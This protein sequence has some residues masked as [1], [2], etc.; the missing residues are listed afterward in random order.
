MKDGRIVEAGEAEAL[1]RNPR[2]PYTR[3]LMAAAFDLAAV[4][5]TAATGA[6]AP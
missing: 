5:G 4:E 2:E 1:T 6:T 3:A